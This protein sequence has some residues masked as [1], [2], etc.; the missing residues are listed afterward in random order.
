[1]SST[2]ETTGQGLSVAEKRR[3]LAQILQQKAARATRFPLSFAQQRL[4]FLYQLDPASP[5]YNMFS[6]SRLHGPLDAGA[7]GRALA[8]IVRRH[9]A[10]RTTFVA[11]EGEPVQVIAPPGSWRLESEDLGGRDEAER[12]AEVRRRV[13]AEATRPFDL[14]GP[15]FRARLLR[16]GPEEHVLLLC[17]HHVVSDG[18]S[19]EVL[20]RE[21]DALYTAFAR[22]EP[23][24]LPEPPLQYADFAVWQ[25]ERLRG[26][27]LEPHLA[28]WR[29]RLAGAPAVLELPTD[30]PRPAAQSFR[31]A[32]LP[33]ELGAGLTQ[34]LHGLARREGCT[35]FVTLLAA[36]QV[37]L[38]RYAGVEDVVVGV[39]IA[40][41]TRRET[42]GLIG[43][44]VNTLPLRVDLS[45][46]P[47]FTELAGRVRESLL[48]AHAHQELPFDK[49]V[50]ELRVERS[51]GHNPVFQVLLS[52]QGL[53]RPFEFGG[54]RAVPFA[55]ESGTSKFDLS[56]V[57]QEDDSALFGYLEFSTDLFEAATAER[58]RGHLRTLLEQAAADPGRRIS[59]LPLLSPGERRRVVQEWNAT[60]RP[61]P[62]GPPVHELVAEQARRR[63][64]AP[65][66]VAGGAALTYA[67]LDARADRLAAHLRER[68]AGPET[69]VGVLLERTPELVVAQLAVLKAGAAYLP[70]DPSVPDERIA[71]MLA[72]AAAPL[73]LASVATAVR[74]ESFGS[75]VVR[76]DTPHPPAPSPTRGEGENDTSEFKGREA[77]PQNWGRVASLSEPG[78][79][80]P[81]DASSVSAVEEAVLPSP[82]A[83]EGPG[84]GGLPSRDSL[85]YVIYT[86]GSTGM[87]KGVE[88]THGALLNLV[89]WHRDAFGVTEDDRATQ[90]A[91]LGFD[92]SVWELWPYLASGAAVYLV[93]DEETRTSP[94]AL[95]DF[96]LGRGITAA[97]APTP[98]AE[99][100][101]ALEWPAEAPLR[102]LL[103]GGDALRS[104]P[105]DG[106]PFVLV[107]NYGPTENTVVAT[108][109]AVAAGRGSGRAPGIGRP[110]D[111]VR[112]YVL[113][114]HMEPAPVGV[115][116]ELCVGGAQV[117]RGYLG[118][119]ELTAA[120]FVPDPF[121]G[122]PGA[123]MYRT[124]DRVRWL[125]SGELEFLGRLDRQIKVRGFRIEP[126][127]VEAVLRQAPGV[128][129]AAAEVRADARGEGRLVGWVVAA[130]ARR[131]EIL[132]FARTRLPEYMVPAALVSLDAFPLTPSGKTDR[133]ALP[134]PEFGADADAA[135]STPVEE[136]LAGIWAEVLGLRTVGVRE[137]FFALGGHSLLA[138][139]VV[140]RTREVLAVELP[141]RALF[142]APT[143]AALAER[144]EA[145]R[146][147]E[148]PALPPV[149]PVGRAGPLPL[150]FAQERLWFLDRLQP[151]SPF[152]NVPVALRLGGPLHV[153]A[154]ARALGEI[155]RR[156]EALRTVFAEVGGV[157]AQVVVP[158]CGWT[159]PVE[160]LS[161]LE[162]GGRAAAAKRRAAEDAARPFDLRRGPLF[163]AA[164]LRLGAEEHVLLLGMHHI[165][166]DGWSLGVLFGELA[167]LYAAFREGGESPLPE[168]AVQYADYAA[169]Q[170]EQ[171]RG[172][173][174]DRQLGW[175]RERLAGAPE[176]LELPTDHPR[177]AAQTF[178]GAAEPVGLSG[179]LLERLQALAR[180]EGT[181]LYMTLLGAFQAL[182]SRYGGGEDVVVGS[183]VAGRT[184]REVEG[185]IGFFV[186]TLALRTD[187]SGD[188]T[189]RETL[190]RVRE[191]TL[192]AYEHQEVPFEK[193]VAELRP[194]RSLGHSPLV[195]AMLTLR[196]AGVAEDALP[197]LRTQWMDAQLESAKFDLSLSVAATPRGLLGELIYA[198]DLFERGT[199]LRMLGHLGRVLEQVAG[200]AEVRLSALELL[201]EAERAQ[202]LEAWNRT[203]AE[204]PPDRCV[205]QLFEE[206][207]AR[208][209]GSVAVV[210]REETLS[211][212]ELGARAGRLAR[213]LRRLGVG[214][215]ARVGICLERSPEMVVAVL[216]VLGA[217]GA[218][219]PLDPAF[220][221]ERLGLMAADS[222]IA[223][224]LTQEKLRGLL[225]GFAG[226][227]V[228]LDGPEGLASDEEA[229]S[230][231]RTFALPHSP[232][233]DNL[234][235]VIYTSGSTGAPKGVLVTHRGLANYLAWFDRVVLGPDGFA[236][237]LVSRLGFDAHVRQLFPP[238]L[239]GEPV[240]VL[241]EETVADPDALLDALAAHG[242]VS[243]GGVPSLWSAVLERVRSGARARP[244]GLVAV[245]LGGEALPPEL[246][247]RTFAVFPE[248]ALW[249]HY[250][251]TE[252]TVNT[253]AARVRPGEPV[254]LGRPVGNVRV[255]L[256]DAHGSPVPVGVPGE[257]HV[258]GPGVARGY[259][260]RPDATAEKFVPDPFA[261]EPGARMYRTGD[262]LRWRADGG[263]EF[264]GRVDAQVK[265]RGFRIEPGEIQAVLR[266][267]GG[268][269]DCAVVVRE[270]GPGEKRLVAYVVGRAGADELRAHL[271]G[272]LPDYM[273]PAA[274]VMLDSLPLTPNGKLDRGALPAPDRAADA[275]RYVEPRTAAEE[276]V[277]G[278]W[279]EVLGLETVGVEDDFFALGGHSLLATRVVSRVR[280]AFGTELPLRALFEAPTVAG[281]AERVEGLRRAGEPI[282]PP[283][284]PT[285][286]TGPLPLSFAQ[287]RLW[288][289]HRMDPAS[290]VYNLPAALRLGGALDV[291]ALGRALGEIVRRHE[292]LRTVFVEA[293]GSPVQ[294]VA[295]FGGFA[296]PV[297][298]L[299]RLEEG[300]RAAAARRSV[301]EGAARPFDLGEGPLFRASLLRLAEEEHVLLLCMHHVVSDGWSMGVLFGELSA[302]YAAYRQER[303]SPLPELPVQYPDYAVWQRRHLSGE[304]VERQL[305]CWR[306]RLADAP[307]LLELP[308]D[309]P[310]PPVPAYEGS[311][312]SVDLP[313][314]LLARLKALGRREGATLYMTLLAASQALLSK[315]AGSEDVVVGSPIAGRTRGETEGLIGFFVNTLVLRT[316]L[317]GDPGFREAL[318]RVRGVTLGAYEHQELPF[319]KLVAELQPER[320]LGHTPLFQVMF[321]LVR[322]AE[323]VTGLLAG[324]RA[325]PVAVEI[326]T[327]KFDLNLVFTEYPD[328][329]QAELGY[330]T[331]LFE[332]GTIARMLGHL[333]RVL[334]QVAGDGDPRLSALELL[335]GAEREQV[336]AAWNR[337]AREYPDTPLHD[338]FAAW[339][340]R[341]PDAVAVRFGGETV[342]YG[343]LDRRADAIAR[344]L[345][346]AGGG[347]E[348]RVGILAEPGPAL[349]AGVLGILRAGGAYLPLD[350]AYPA[351]RLAFM[352]DDAGAP[353]V[354]AQ[355]ELLASLPP[356]GARVVPLDET[357]LPPAPSPARGEGEHD[358]VEDGSAVAVA[359]CSLFPVPCSLSLAYVIYTSGSTGRPKGV[360]VE[361]R[362]LSNLVH[363]SAA[364]LGMGPGDTTLCLASVSFDVW[365]YQALVPLAMGGAVRMVPREQAMDPPALVEAMED[366]TAMFMVPALMRQLAPVLRATHPA[367][368]PGVRLA[369]TGG[370]VVPSELQAELREAFPDADVRV[371]YGPTEATVA[372]SSHRVGGGA[373]G[374]NLIGRPFSNTAFYVVDAAGEPVPPGVPGELWIGGA[375]VARG[376]L[377]RPALTARAFV[378]DAFGGAARSGARLYRSGDRV[379][380]TAEGELEFLGRVDTQVKVRGFRVEPGEIEA[381]LRRHPG[382]RECAVVVREDQPGDR[383]LV[384]YVEG[385]AGA[386][387]LREHLRRDLPEYMLPA[388]FVAMGA[389]PL[390]PSGKLDR[391]AL[392]AP[393]FGSA[394]ERYV[395]PRTPAEEVLAGIWAEVLELE[396]VGVEENFFD[397]GGH[398]L[399]AT[400]VVARARAALGAEISLRALFEAP[401]VAGLAGR[402]EAALREGAGVRLPPVVPAP[403]DGSPLP[404]SFAQQRL[405]FIDQLEPGSATYNLPVP[406]R[407]RGALDARALAAALSGLARRHESLRTVFADVEGEPVQVVLPAAPV[408]LPIVDLGALPEAA[409]RAEVPRLAA[410][411]A[412]RPFDL[413]RGPL[414]RAALLRLDAEEHALLV[415]MHHVVGDGWSMGVFFRELSAL[416]EASVEGRPSLLPELPVQYADF[417]V[418]QRAHL[419]DEV[420]R[421]Q[422]RYWRERL[423]G[424]P[425]LLELPTDRPRPAVA[426]DRGGAV[427]F[428]LTSDT[429]RALRALARREGATLFTVLLAGFQALLSRYAGSADVPVGTTAAGRSRL[430]TEGL[431]GFFVNT[432]VLRA[433]I[434]GGFTGRALVEQARGRVLE[435][436]AHQDV[437]FE[438]LVEELRVERTRAHAPLF[439]AMFTFDPAGTGAGARLGGVQVEPLGAQSGRAKFDLTLGMGA[440][441]ERLAGGLSY[442]TDLWECATVRRMAG[443]LATL[444]EGLAREPERRVAELPLL[445]DAERARVLEE[446]NATDRAYPAGPC[447]HDLFAAQA[448]LTPDAVAVSWR[449]AA[450]TYAELDRR[451]GRLAHALR[452]LGVGPE[453]RVGVCMSRTPEL[454]VALLGVLRAGGAY[455][456]LDPAYPRERLGWMLEDAAIDVVLTES[457]LAERLPGGAAGLL[458]LDRADLSAEPDAAPAS[459]AGPENLSHV[460][461]T[462]GSTGRPKGVMI[463]HS[464]VVV[465]LHWLRE[466]VSDEERASV[467]FSTSVNFDVSVAEIWGTLCWGGRLVLVENALE[468]ATTDEPVVYASMVPSAAAELLRAGGIPASVR[469]LNLGGEALPA[470]LA[471]GLYALGHVERVGNLYGPTEDTTYSTY[472]L[473]GRGA[474]EVHVGRPVANTRAYVL[475]GE[476]QPAPVGVVGEL[477]LAGDGLARG[478][479]GRPDAT[480][481]R[482]LPCPFGA[483]GSR[484]YRVMDR[485]RWRSDGTLEYL[486]RT[487]FQVKVRGFR[488]EPGEIEAALLR[489]PA[490]REAV[491]VVREDAPGDRR[492]VAYVT[493]GGA[494]AAELRAHAGARLPEYMV[495]S[496][497][498]V[499]DRLPLTPNGKTDR[500]ALPAP[501]RAADAG[502]SGHVAPRD[503]LELALA[504][505][506]EEVLGVG[507]V[508]VR[509]DF[510]ALGG[511]SLLAVRLMA[512]VERVTGVRL[513]LALLFTASTVEKLAAELRGG[514]AEGERSPLV[515]IRP[516]GSRTPLFLVHPVGGDVLA[517]ADLARHLDPDQPVYGLRSRGV[518]D[519]EEPAATVEEMA[520]DYL[521]AL[522]EVQPAGPYRI[523]GWSM[524]GVVAFEMARRLEAAGEGVETL[525]LIDSYLPALHHRAAPVDERVRV[526]TFAADLGLPPGGLELAAEEGGGSYL[527]RVLEGARA[528]GL[529]PPDVDA[530]RLE[531]LYAV[532]GAN[533]AALHAYPARPYGGAVLLLRA[534][535]HDPADAGSAGWERV[536]RGGVE[537]HVVPGS[538]FTLVRE[539]H[540]AA[541]AALL[542]RR[543]DGRAGPA[544]H[545]RVYG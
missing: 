66:V 265:V 6:A 201:G 31:G 524:G 375:G 132:A 125:A 67:G 43:L 383:R 90:L 45:G 289:L 49:L 470:P 322:R 170:R 208:T 347:P 537:L 195:Q 529:L 330:R 119:P 356:V 342:R 51:L 275:D 503:E 349:V 128:A 284:V 485:V 122:V 176:L 235:Y 311:N 32:S 473:V 369:F 250:G 481:E 267:H 484:M 21:L 86:S 65:A 341:A 435:A 83:G 163:R 483:P 331:D 73:V 384:A 455:V 498:V 418:W 405:W 335:D 229:L 224:L 519:G 538:H 385:D 469:T 514:R 285:D 230:H 510:F 186:N 476:L 288:F 69:R 157:A 61:R 141:L 104:R 521:R 414:L 426:G 324:L 107:N 327:V 438:R 135:P 406:L 477:Y 316:D 96:L 493:G 17:V 106:L 536:A 82:L 274:F 362:A 46:D 439:Q 367:G 27:G 459:G 392:P 192:G 378:P 172:E 479:A 180:R 300:A 523:G 171:L 109:G 427:G 415:C 75:E 454:V 59:E 368:L 168:P 312:D 123:R 376:Y 215:E 436:H 70:I 495:P 234:A 297:E 222:G 387:A 147:A 504:R 500:G 539:P 490:V 502:G 58:M 139:R 543:L 158:F 108:S 462:S 239:R 81:A 391:R 84:E 370:D 461:F 258:G 302:L 522:R 277:A 363:H 456:P 182:L 185:L 428:A 187:L 152:Y 154:L 397:L 334:E 366:V 54:V 10:L 320:S 421:T 92:A 120:A 155:V 449:G 296:L 432:L 79:D 478:Y 298:D 338:L 364:E 206:Q 8:E 448:A 466:A 232:S 306:E 190:R 533:L 98:M 452:R 270:D 156:H 281:L 357:P 246:A 410:E 200:D 57:L 114:R 332:R 19:M 404:L 48:G 110:T 36:F 255:Y 162:E 323:P 179:E 360:L 365:V 153:A 345:R 355:P 420:L 24:P 520:A 213:R 260:G 116:G 207:A 467:L 417:A 419:S 9:E 238:L 237:P 127:E 37:L 52:P 78:G 393:D 269:D 540:A 506:W 399:L 525:A 388:A 264:V 203:E 23:S 382:V 204:Y 137:S 268:V 496:A 544:P 293:E 352:L 191:V 499:L 429:T 527:R 279:A 430:E 167:A 71:F 93:A 183:P 304:T 261:A 225:P 262:R 56:L 111:N 372:C 290:S 28:F 424:M 305:A 196:D 16:V 91:G 256:L 508:G 437:P 202:V 457:R 474:E 210:F 317:S 117:A 161:R 249:N 140:S 371:A 453:T 271:R 516:E 105:R 72:D 442:R 299:S 216:A 545:R 138:T 314:E 282:L 377:G 492:I 517:Y 145:L 291:E 88:V 353:V 515:P 3:L 233:P 319:E 471:Q 184:R 307:A 505:T 248:V 11:E 169:W 175:W 535:E 130:E 280:E 251:P 29:E 149:V 166:G 181:T 403:R 416:Y 74:V 408:R 313:G 253:T 464:S 308:T 101:L 400:R 373:A 407:L 315:Y 287:E 240:R 95:R 276:V 273:V 450:T 390:T 12:E 412:E 266:R 99:A 177:P 310:R 444:L 103:T 489:H 131:G 211:Y 97:F 228:V 34:A 480:A 451:S 361:H 402:A 236:L 173:A 374:R 102:V 326:P 126:G 18:W 295:P 486:G 531:Q 359:G 112:A 458:L 62:A 164:L 488:I 226:E 165:V 41:R 231:S 188:P 401:T 212:A 472:A 178:R 142:E 328:G 398:S 223:V 491:A 346:S 343:E 252:A 193:L 494:S 528:A 209:P 50:E 189:F 354:L 381:A 221:A 242:R 283:V 194:E 434:G 4:W 143:V 482:W 309:C 409:R 337:T 340:R 534:A 413:R 118:R 76:V 460:I 301:A 241:P 431:I 148:R 40:G 423:A 350:P 509:D 526:L 113:D 42:E 518:A 35:L 344:R 386:D 351:E 243:F 77:L 254:S 329:L 30:R 26:P 7:L 115:P 325:E 465:L 124:G 2:L 247:E 292:A 286:R 133:R 333:R 440:E 85:A 174:L 33:V 541:L 134:E 441:G 20:T 379:R 394:E 278:I 197:G 463:R 205:H 425:P 263:L 446:W 475:D 146:R 214:P 44:F 542:G 25:R 159:L 227:A 144:V 53:A 60:D 339:A 5:L 422:A 87:P 511:H 217:G 445:D 303:P 507:P 150:S 63:P 380:W 487:D 501:D 321:A 433:E 15:L 272:S 64:D 121:S 532:F 100:L 336:L 22:G 80:L 257:A 259:L 1:M 318:R 94:A 396:R 468:L 89:H 14:A 513:P 411:D 395:A 160:D 244:E 512:Q 447:V 199:A 198:T 218:Y 497:V 358:S 136:V 443:H 530:G 245:L 38:A 55:A 47:V 294:A 68:G 129:D 39:P 151:G 13:Q 348:T 219:V 220:P 389:L